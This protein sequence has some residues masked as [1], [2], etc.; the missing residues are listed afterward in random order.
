MILSKEYLTT[1]RQRMRC[2]L[3][4]FPKTFQKPLLNANNSFGLFRSH[5]YGISASEARIEM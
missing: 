1:Y 3:H 2:K 4:P 5:Q